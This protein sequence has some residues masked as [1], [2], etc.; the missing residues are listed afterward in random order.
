MKSKI[1]AV[2]F[3][4]D[5][6]SFNMSGSESTLYYNNLDNAKARLREGYDECIKCLKACGV[7]FE[8]VEGFSD[9]I[10]STYY[11]IEVDSLVAHTGNLYEIETED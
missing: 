3:F 1:Y 11:N 8:E 7:E 10:N 9:D 2:S 5:D 4:N 6:G